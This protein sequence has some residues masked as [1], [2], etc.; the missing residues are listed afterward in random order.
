M[1]IFRLVLHSFILAAVNIISIMFGFG[2][3]RFLKQYNQLAVQVPTAVIFSIIVFTAWIVIIKYKNISKIFPEGWLQFLLIFLWSIIWLPIIFL[4]LHYITQGY[5]TYFGNIYWNWLFQ[6]P[7][8]M[9]AVYF[10]YLIIGSKS[11]KK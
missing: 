5:L 1:K 8:N 4:P 7:A 3:H 9:A 10:A 2:I 6:V 11:K